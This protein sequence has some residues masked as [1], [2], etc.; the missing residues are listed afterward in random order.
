[1]LQN[2]TST[3]AINSGIGDWNELRVVADGSNLSYHINDVLVWSDTDSDLTSGRVGVTM[4]E[5][6]SVSDEQ[7]EVDWAILDVIDNGG[8]P[9]LNEVNPHQR[10][11]NEAA[12]K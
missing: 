7:M 10:A 4:T 5:H 9:V 6:S 8:S 12:K 11:L 2:W 3:T 1:M